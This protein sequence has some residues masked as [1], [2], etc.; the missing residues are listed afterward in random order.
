MRT[1]AVLSTLALFGC[2]NEPTRTEIGSF[3]P[4]VGAE[5]R[6]T[7][8]QFLN[9]LNPD[10]KLS[11]HSESV[12]RFEKFKNDWLALKNRFRNTSIEIEIAISEADH[13]VEVMSRGIPDCPDPEK[14]AP[15]P[16]LKER[17]QNME[18]L[19]AEMSKLANSDA[20]KNQKTGH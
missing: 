2:Q 13:Q 17:F 18:M 9:K 6:S 16:E 20:E 19:L 14:N 1:V 5:F 10:C 11:N 8:R 4:S 12:E 3:D 15:G 7:T